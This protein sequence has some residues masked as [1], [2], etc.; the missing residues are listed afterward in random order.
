MCVLN[1]QH[2]INEQRNNIQLFVDLW[3]IKSILQ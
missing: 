2:T 3:K 1:D